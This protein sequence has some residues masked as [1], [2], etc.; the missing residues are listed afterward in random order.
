MANKSTKDHL[1]GI[2]RRFADI[3]NGEHA[4]V[5]AVVNPDGSPISAGGGGAGSDRELVVSTYICRTAFTGASIGDTITATQI[6]DVSGTPS[7]VSTIWRNQTTAADLAGAPSAANLELVG[8]GAIT[9]AQ[10]TAQGLASESTLQDVV[11]ALFNSQSLTDAQLRAS[12]VPVAPNITR[13]SGAVDAN[14]QRVTLATDGPMVTSVGATNDAAATTDTGT[15][16][17]IALFKRSL[18]RLTAL[19]TAQTISVDVVQYVATSAV[20][21]QSAAVNLATNR[22]VLSAT[23][24]CWVTLGSNP[25]ASKAAGSFYIPD[26]G[27]TYPILVPTPGT[28]KFAVL[29]DSEAGVLSVIES[30]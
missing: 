14:T 1:L 12:P 2:I 22:V 5:I 29:Q 4:E 28:T 7:T 27:T 17:L 3:G 6:I 24:A 19:L 21:A 26:G 18:Q 8:S 13:G 11:Y 16:S 30:A 9:E 25:I 23:K 15:F 10:L 20:S